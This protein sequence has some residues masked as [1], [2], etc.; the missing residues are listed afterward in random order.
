MGGEPCP[1]HIR[2]QDVLRRWSVI[3]AEAL[4]CVLYI[5]YSY[6]APYDLRGLQP[7]CHKSTVK[8][9]QLPRADI[10]V[11]SL[12]TKGGAPHSLHWKRGDEG[13]IHLIYATLS[14]LGEKRVWM[15]G[16][17]GLPLSAKSL[18]LPIISHLVLL[19]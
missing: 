19:M 6:L 17:G 13:L 2:N 12:G 1:Q 5:R 11:Y 9:S 16:K 10:C 18:A 4:Q 14:S 15:H 7:R 8:L 3:C